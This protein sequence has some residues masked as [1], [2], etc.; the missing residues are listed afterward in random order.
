VLCK[1]EFI[2]PL[3]QK[4][5]EYT[6]LVCDLLLALNKRLFVVSLLPNRQEWQVYG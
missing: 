2:V 5:D 4:G 6:A 1:D 3:W